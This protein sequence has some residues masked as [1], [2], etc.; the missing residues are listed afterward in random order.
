MRNEQRYCGKLQKCN[1]IP[2][3]LQGTK[4][5]LPCS[6]KPAADI[7]SCVY[8][9]EC[10]AKKCVER[11][12]ELANRT[13]SNCTKLQLHALMTINSKPDNETCKRMQE[14]KGHDNSER[15]PK[16]MCREACCNDLE[17]CNVEDNEAVIK[18]IIKGRSPTM[19]D[20]S[21]AHR[22]AVDWSFGRINLDPKIQIRYIDTKH[23]IADML[24]KV[25]FT[26][27]EWN[28]LLRLFNIMSFSMFS[29]SHISNFLSDPTGKQSAMSKKRSRGGF[30]WR[31]T[32]GKSKAYGTGEGETTQLGS[33][34]P[35]GMRKTLHRI[36]V[37]GQSGEMP[38]N[39][40]EWK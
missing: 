12:C 18:M 36:W 1:L 19:R 17:L 15:N 8:D 23:Q 35:R 14:Q 16:R 40:K 27:D 26:R 11:Y 37:S 20:V 25:S 39:E 34:Q 33:T 31:L 21:R 28:H 9:I 2:E 5:K 29:C 6:G 4:E 30:R 22:V 13:P 24:S 3:S 32:N 7:S 38:M 10:H